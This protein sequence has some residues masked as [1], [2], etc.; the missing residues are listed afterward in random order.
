[1]KEEL[2][3]KEEILA[4]IKFMKDASFSE[5]VSVFNDCISLYVKCLL[6]FKNSNK[7]SKKCLEI[8][9][10]IYLIL[11]KERKLLNLIENSIDEINLDDTC[12]IIDMLDSLNDKTYNH[13][14]VVLSDIEYSCE[15][16]SDLYFYDMDDKQDNLLT[17][18]KYQKDVEKLTNKKLELKKGFKS[19]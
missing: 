5:L 6:T 19:K 16:K 9:K 3:E 8:I 1:M 18:D 15:I 11:R 10:E 13:F 7:L 2:S 4:Q 17:N 12:D 14:D